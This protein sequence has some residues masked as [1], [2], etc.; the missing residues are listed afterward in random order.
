MSHEQ[1][2][3]AEFTN[4]MSHLAEFGPPEDRLPITALTEVALRFGG[5]ELRMRRSER[6]QVVGLHTSESKELAASAVAENE[7]GLVALPAVRPLIDRLSS[8][9]TDEKVLALWREASPRLRKEWREQV[10][11]L[12]VEAVKARQLIR[13]ADEVC[14]AADSD[15]LAGLGRHLGDRLAELEK[16]RRSEDRGTRAESFPYWK[17]VL[18]AIFWG[19]G[20]GYTIDLLSKGAPWYAPFLLWLVI[21]IFTF[22]IALGC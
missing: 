3:A 16:A 8:G 6:L 10:A 21:A 7:L 4:A 14:D 9:K 20:V 17:I 12:D 1:R 11:D 2:A 22:C 5:C 19:I 18:A 15:G 13:L